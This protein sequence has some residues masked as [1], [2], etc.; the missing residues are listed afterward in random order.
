MTKRGRHALVGEWRGVAM[1]LSD[2]GY[3]HLCRPGHI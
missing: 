2:A 3:I 1:D